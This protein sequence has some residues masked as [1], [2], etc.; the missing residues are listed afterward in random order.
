MSLSLLLSPPQAEDLGGAVA[1]GAVLRQ[2][3]TGAGITQREL[4][5][6][7][8]LHRNYLGALERGTVANPG[9]AT[10]TRLARAL[11]VSVGPLAESFVRPLPEQLV[12]SGSSD[13]LRRPPSEPGAEPLG[14]ALRL[15]RRRHELTRAV[16]AERT[17]MHKNYIGSLEEGAIAS[18][19]LLTV[20]R[21]TIGLQ[22]CDA[23]NVETLAGSVGALAR[24]F[25]GEPVQARA[26]AA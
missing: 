7:E 16:L 4:A 3:R 5:A 21:L 17:G 25:A 22:G 24:I 19:G 11:G 9:L 23:R 13:E 20:T 14:R 12:P 8:G 6:R 26:I 10:A 1:L 18:P 15:L 2:L